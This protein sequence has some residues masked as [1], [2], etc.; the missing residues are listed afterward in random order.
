MRWVV[1]VGSVAIIIAV[2]ILAGIYTTQSTGPGVY[3]VNR[4]TGSV[5]YCVAGFCHPMVPAEPANVFDQFP[6][7]PTSAV[8]R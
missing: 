1:A 3:V 5:R 2:V 4:F 7:A 8:T 6:S